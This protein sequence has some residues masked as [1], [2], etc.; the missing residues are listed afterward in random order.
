MDTS[1]IVAGAAI[2]G[3][4]LLGVGLVVTWNRNGRLQAGK[5]G[6]LKAEVSN[7]GKKVDALACNVRGMDKTVSE[8]KIHC[9][10]VSGRL[11]ERM[12]SVERQVSE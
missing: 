3:N 2:G 9:A 11:D 1:L 6:E 10:D 12:R 5:Y 4:L 8:F 7:T